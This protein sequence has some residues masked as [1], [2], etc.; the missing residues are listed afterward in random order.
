MSIES[1]NLPLYLY[2]AWSKAYIFTSSMD[3]ASTRPYNINGNSENGL[4]LAIIF[5]Q[6]ILALIMILS[7]DYLQRS[8]GKWKTMLVLLT[9]GFGGLGI[10]FIIGA[11]FVR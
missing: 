10:R 1:A 6:E 8:I 4:W 3:W 2:I 5:C 7:G 9:I 11:I